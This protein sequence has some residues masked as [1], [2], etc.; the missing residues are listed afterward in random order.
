MM[1]VLNGHGGGQLLDLLL[2]LFLLL[3][4]VYQAGRVHGHLGQGR[5]RGLSLVQVLLRVRVS[6]PFSLE[7]E[8]LA[9]WTN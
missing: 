8:G 2:D 3:P 7:F 1:K 4:N 5:K 6:H 9:A